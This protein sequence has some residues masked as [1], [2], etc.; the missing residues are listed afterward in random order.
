M[1]RWLII[2]L[3][4]VAAYSCKKSSQSDCKD[5]FIFWGGEPAVDGIGWFFSTNPD[6]SDFMVLDSLDNAYKIDSLPVHVCLSKTNN[7]FY[8]FCAGEHYYYHVNYILR[9]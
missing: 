7:R 3:L 1:K 4:G 5:G 2:I 8:C 9:R 6:R